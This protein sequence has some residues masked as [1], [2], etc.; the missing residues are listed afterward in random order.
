M[1]DSNATSIQTVFCACDFSET[2]ALALDHAVR[3]AR[4]HEARLVLA[5]VVEPIPLGPYPVLMAPDN[6]LAIRDLARKRMETLAERAR[7]EGVVADVRVDMGSPGSELVVMAEDEAADVIVIGTRGLTG[8]QH[9]M[10]GSTAEYVVRVSSCP[11]LTIHPS[12]AVS[13]EPAKTVILP[14]DLSAATGNATDAFVALFGNGEKPHVILTFADRTPPY[15]EPFRHDTLM[16]MHERDV[17]KEEIERRM[18]PAVSQLRESGFE[19]ETAVLDGDPVSVV[20]ELATERN[21]DLIVM[22]SHGRSA[23]LNALLG[24]IAQRIVQHSPCPV[25]TVRP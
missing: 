20:T 15:L 13:E 5:H 24:K 4:R 16:K 2:G 10:L 12:D 14:T 25:L 19:V 22:N 6:E 7:S 18:E 3:L 1:S 9:V 21:A 17:V 11:V 8:F 23:I